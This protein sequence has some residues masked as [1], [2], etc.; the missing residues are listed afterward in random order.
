MVGDGIND[1]PALAHADFGIAM[2]S[3]ANHT[4]IESADVILSSSRL[5]K[6][7][8]AIELSKATTRNM[9]TNIIFALIVAFSLMIGVLTKHIFL[10]VGMLI[11]ELSVLI[12][13]INAIRLLKFKSKDA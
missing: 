8:Y 11:H 5:E 10:S 3:Y 13:I 2:G 12:V 1:A 7:P 9:K 4:A 6:L